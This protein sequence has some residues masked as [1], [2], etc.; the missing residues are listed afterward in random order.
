MAVTSPQG[1]IALV[2]LASFNDPP[3][4]SSYRVPALTRTRRNHG[5]FL[6]G[7]QL[8]TVY[9]SRREFDTLGVTLSVGAGALTITGSMTPVQARAMARALAAAADAVEALGG[10][11]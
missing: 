7:D 9:S 2:P 3:P 4:R 11:Q 8:A 1:E 6:V 10:R 5:V